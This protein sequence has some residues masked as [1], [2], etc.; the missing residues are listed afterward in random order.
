M[1][2]LRW[3]PRSTRS[4]KRWALTSMCQ[5][6]PTTRAWSSEAARWQAMRHWTQSKAPPES[7]IPYRSWVRKLSGAERASKAVAAAISAGMVR[8][9]FLKGML[10]SQPRH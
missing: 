7:L 3:Q 2:A 9:G 4:T 6:R 1:T 10:Q 8:R 5:P